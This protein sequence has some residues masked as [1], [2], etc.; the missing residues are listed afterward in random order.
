MT[1]PGYWTDENLGGNGRFLTMNKHM[2]RKGLNI[3]RL[4]LV[5]TG[6][7][8]LI[9][10]EQDI[11]EAQYEAQRDVKKGSGEKHSLGKFET[12]VKILSEEESNEL[13][14]FEVD[15]TQVAYMGPFVPPVTPTHKDY[16][17]KC[18]CL[19]FISQGSLDWV[20]GR[21]TL[22]RVIKKIRYWEPTDYREATFNK[23]LDLFRKHWNSGSLSLEEYIEAQNKQ[24]SLSSILNKTTSDSV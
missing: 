7:H 16:L 23:S 14:R 8:Q 6:F 15:S 21:K 4:F 3:E 19:N 9:E 17:P 24:K 18:L 2:A 22:Q 11:L 20:N 5:K 1:Y 12:K 13:L 10:T